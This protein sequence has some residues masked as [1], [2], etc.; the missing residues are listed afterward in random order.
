MGTKADRTVD[1]IEVN[2]RQT[3]PVQRSSQG[4]QKCPADL[5][6]PRRHGLGG[7]DDG[8]SPLG[9]TGQHCADD[10]FAFSSAV[11]LGRVEQRDSGIDRGVPCLLDR[12]TRE[13]RVVA[14]IPQVDRSPQA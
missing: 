2:R 7:D 8:G 14:P 13:V 11:H 12:V 3:E 10:P 1:L 4:L 5:Q 6:L 9:I